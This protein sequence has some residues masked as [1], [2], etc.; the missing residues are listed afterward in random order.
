MSQLGAKSIDS[1]S[2][3]DE[4]AEVHIYDLDNI[5]TIEKKLNKNKIVVWD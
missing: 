1:L 4:K 5:M 3:C 2:N